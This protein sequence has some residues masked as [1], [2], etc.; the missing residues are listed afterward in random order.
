MR[1]HLPLTLVFLAACSP[2]DVAG[3]DRAVES[4][5]IQLAAAEGAAQV[6]AFAQNVY[7]GTNVDL[8]LPA[9]LSPDPSD[10]LPAMLLA[11]AVLDETDFTVRSAGIAREVERTRPHAIGLNEISA[12][13]VDLRPLGVPV[14]AHEDFLTE[15]LAA[16][17][18]RGL[19][20]TVAASIQGLTAAPPLPAG[21]TISI[22]D[23]DVLLVDADRVTLQPGILAQNYTTN[24]GPIATGVNL[25]RGFVIAPAVIAGRPYRFVATHLES[26]LAGFPP[27]GLLRAAQMAE[28][29]AYLPGALPTVIMGDL[30]DPAGSLMYQLAIGAGF[31]DV[32]NA[33]H[34]ESDGYTCCNSDNLADEFPAHTKRIDFLFARGFDGPA[35]A[36]SGRIDR[37]GDTRSARVQGPTH[38]L[39]PSD[40][41]GLV[42][43]L[44]VP[45]V[46]DR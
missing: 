32:W 12:I 6:T 26:D 24:V 28:L 20:Y 42:S 43:T 27:F 41:A 33:I 21:A 29:L 40:H 31:T 36:V 46:M 5:A 8:V 19:N 14:V 10:D 23:R 4:T 44:V 30:N 22:I 11:A 13:D 15:L 45:A 39:W 16:L 18:A 1:L 3:P 9:L 17:A 34:P 35:A 37:Y 25:V 2:S 38:S 7:V